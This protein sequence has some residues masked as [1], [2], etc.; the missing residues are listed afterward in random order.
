VLVTHE[1][2][3]AE[4]AKRVVE[5]RDG[6]LIR[7]HAVADRHRA[8]DDLLSIEPVPDTELEVVG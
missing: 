3:V 2:E 4:Y 8:A 1:P 7:D 6:R 5:M